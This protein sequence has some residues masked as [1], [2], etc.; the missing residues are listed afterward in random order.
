VIKGSSVG[1]AS[2]LASGGSWVRS[3]LWVNGLSTNGD[4]SRTYIGLLWTCFRSDV[5]I[6][7]NNSRTNFNLVRVY[8]AR[9]VHCDV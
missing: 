6:C 8:V 4:L 7:F 1:R 3:P 2:W 9:L 5:A